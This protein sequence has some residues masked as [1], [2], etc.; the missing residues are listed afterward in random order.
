MDKDV[1]IT[2]VN[3]ETEGFYGV[4]YAVTTGYLKAKL[5]NRSLFSPVQCAVMQSEMCTA[6]AQ[7]LAVIAVFQ[8]G[9]EEGSRD[10]VHKDI[11]LLTG[12]FCDVITQYYRER[13]ESG[14][15][16]GRV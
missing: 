13:E 3:I 4:L 8:P 2:K 6:L 12:K 9:I 1:H 11:T 14:T 10:G 16:G 7:M 15:G 5:V